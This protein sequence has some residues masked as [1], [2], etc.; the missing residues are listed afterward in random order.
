MRKYS[1]LTKDPRCTIK[2]LF[3]QLQLTTGANLVASNSWKIR[4]TWTWA[5][6]FTSLII[7]FSGTRN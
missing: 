5:W 3:T 4:W 2:T 6:I 7:Q 1:Q